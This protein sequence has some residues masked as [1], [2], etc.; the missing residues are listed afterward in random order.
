[1]SQSILK[2]VSLLGLS[3]TLIPSVMVFLGYIEFPLHK[4]LML[5]GTLLW[6]FSRPFTLE[7]ESS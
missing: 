5:V 2:I 6:F 1:M 7:N 4:T 3:L